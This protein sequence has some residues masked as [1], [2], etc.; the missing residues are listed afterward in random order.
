MKRFIVIL[1]F[2]VLIVT[3]ASFELSQ[4][5]PTRVGNGDDGGDLENATTVKSGILI[6]TRAEAVALLKKL[7]VARVEGLGMLIPETERS[8]ILLVGRDID[9]SKTETSPE[10]RNDA[11]E[12]A[13][14]IGAVNAKNQPVYARTFPEPH[15]ATRFFPAALLL[16]R[17]QLVALH[18]HEALHRAL[19]SD[20]REKER[21]VSR[22]TLAL[23]ASDTSFDRVKD[24]TTRELA[25]ARTESGGAATESI[26]AKATLERASLIEYSYR[27]FFRSEQSSTIAPLASLHSLRSFMYPFGSDLTLG[28][29]I[30]FTFAILPQRSYLGPVGLSTRAK[31]ATWRHYDVDVFGALHLN[32][33]ADGEIKNA[34]ASRD[35]ATVGLSV[36][37]EERL[38]RIENQIYFTPGSQKTQVIEG[39]EQQHTYGSTLGAKVSGVGKFPISPTETF[40]WGGM[41]EV[42]VANAHE[43]RIGSTTTS[44]GRVRVLSIGPEV[45]YTRGDLRLTFSG[46]FIVDSPEGVS[47]DQMGD[48]LGY[49]MGQGSVG[50]AISWQF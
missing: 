25:A 27:S 29:G 41:A 8:D 6:E 26:D 23:T 28:F 13:R 48:L 17:R 4:A 22:I 46:R 34:P 24:I 11:I 3:I 12:E 9:L 50:A 15:A 10:E 21:V 19:P 5:L 18:I 38:Y 39:I 30:E 32:T 16:D 45:G 47:L 20:V 14:A 31:L 44:T 35:S 43:T 42:L 2:T 40:E 7:D 37:R 1:I 49:G 36:R 33:V